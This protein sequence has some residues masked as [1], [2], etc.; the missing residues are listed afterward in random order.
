MTTS[1]KPH[2]HAHKKA[3]IG[4]NMYVKSLVR[5]QKT[6]VDEVDHEKTMKYNLEI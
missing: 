6:K 2:L 1:L 4:H 3:I 5:K